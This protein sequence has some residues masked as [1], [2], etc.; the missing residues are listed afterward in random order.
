MPWASQFGTVARPG[1]SCG[2]KA[3]TTMG[4]V[5]SLVSM[6]WQPSRVQCGPSEPNIFRPVNRQPPSTRVADAVDR[7]TGMSLPT[8]AC[9]EASRS[10]SRT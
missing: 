3:C 6:A 7:P 8:S 9:P 1:A 5:G 2:T 4:A 10:P